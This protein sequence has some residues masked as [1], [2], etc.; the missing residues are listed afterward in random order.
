MTEPAVASSD[1]TNIETSIRRDGDHYVINGRKW[2]SSGA[3]D[4]RC[5]VLIVMGKTDPTRSEARAAV[6][7]PRA[8][9]NAGRA[10]CCACCRCSASTT[11]RTATPRSSSRTCACRPTTSCS[12][13]AAAS[14]SR[15]RASARAASITACAT[16][17]SPSALLERI[18][19][20][21]S[22]ARRV[23]QADRR[24]VD[25]AGAHREL[26]HHD[27][28]GA[29]AGAERRGQDGSPRQQGGAARDRDDQGRGAGDAELRRRLGDPGARRGRRHHRLRPRPHR[30]E[31]AHHAHR[32]RP[33][34]GASQ[35]DRA[36]GAGEVQPEG[37]KQA[38]RPLLRSSIA[39][40][41]RSSPAPAAASAA[42]S[43]SGSRSTARRSWSRAASS[44]P[45]RK[46][47]R[48]SARRAAKRSRTPATS[49][50]RKSCRALVNAAIQKWGGIDVAGL[51]RRR[52]SV[53]RP[54]DRHA[55]RRL[56]QGHGQQRA[57]QLLVVQ[58]G[59]AADGGARRRLDRHH[60]FGRRPARHA[61]DR[62]VRRSRRPPTWRWRATSA[63]S[64][65][66]RT[67]A[68]TAS[69]P[70]WCAPTSPRRC[71]RIPKIYEQTVRVYPLRRIGE[72]DEIAG[73]AVFLAWPERLRS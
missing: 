25:L 24:A 20:R 69:R 45:A 43:P 41:S 58:H 31:R 11:R 60:L 8:D 1:A 52:Q 44:M 2:W 15:R 13:R 27:R 62:R 49:A 28:P 26:P 54:G 67:F 48:R 19:K 5:K 29:A 56:G 71:G 17:A 32:R 39:A 12:A 53:L 61:G 55:R 68:P 3:G 21:L 59:A 38:L 42:R 6:A 51:Q 22:V 36:H 35:S 64:G 47:S 73:A 70:A 14:R 9:G 40:R 23:R 18:C 33:G 72:P 34:R 50:A 7:D 37:A 10:R 57:Q 66:R 30:G 16:S 65:A 46:S 4:T 63:W